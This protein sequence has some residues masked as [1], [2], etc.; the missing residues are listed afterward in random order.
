MAKSLFAR[1]FSRDTGRKSW[2]EHLQAGATEGPP[3]AMEHLSFSLTQRKD[4]WMVE[5]EQRRQAVTDQYWRN[6]RRLQYDQR[7]AEREMKR[8]LEREQRE[9]ERK[10][11]LHELDANDPRRERAE[12]EARQRYQLIERQ[13]ERHHR[14]E[15]QRN[16]RKLQIGREQEKRRITREMKREYKES[17]EAPTTFDPPGPAPPPASPSASG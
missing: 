11:R 1:M 4:P 15:W 9:I 10:F 16:L 12:R 2:K 5:W 13:V 14:E 6:K 7:R 8:V 3:S 17:R